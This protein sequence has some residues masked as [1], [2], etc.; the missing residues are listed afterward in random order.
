[1][2]PLNRRKYKPTNQEQNFC[3]VN[4]EYLNLAIVRKLAQLPK[5]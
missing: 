2:Q 5:M 4:F 1:M 3:P